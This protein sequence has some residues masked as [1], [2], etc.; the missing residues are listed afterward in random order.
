MD[1]QKTSLASIVFAYI[2]SG[3]N[4]NI[5]KFSHEK[6]LFKKH[7]LDMTTIYLSTSPKSKQASTQAVIS[8]T[9]SAAT[10]PVTDVLRVISE[11]ASMKIVMVNIDRFDHV[12]VAKPEVQDLADLRGKKIA[13]SR[14]GSFSDIETRSF[15]RKYGLNPDADVQ[16]L[17]L[18]NTA[19]RTTALL[20]GQVDS[21]VVTSSFIPYVTKAGFSI[22]FDMSTMGAK[23]ANRGVV[24]S[25]ALIQKQPDIV[26][27]IV[28]G[29]VEGTR[30]WKTRPEE[31]KAYLKK[32]TK[33]PDQDI[34]HLYSEASKLLR[35]EPAPDL[36]GIRNAWESIPN[37]KNRGPVDLKNY[38]DARFVA[39]VLKEMK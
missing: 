3:A 31:A 34:D 15:L 12:L 35:S 28:A 19:S 8:G 26:K 22:L 23:F 30:Y 5:L 38:V 24:A 16:L 39:E 36:D 7:G 27:A 32:T 37:L 18:G 1:T 10:A 25:D 2:G 13:V 11:G 21:A 33:L 17:Q 29:F 9:V 4:V 6:G 14:H 20:G